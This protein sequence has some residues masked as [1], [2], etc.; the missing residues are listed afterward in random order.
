MQQAVEDY[1]DK[2]Q[3]MSNNHE[4]AYNVLEDEKNAVEADM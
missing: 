2:L 1:E 4:D 3:E